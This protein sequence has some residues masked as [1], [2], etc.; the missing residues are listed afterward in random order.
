MNIFGRLGGKRLV[1]LIKLG[2]ADG[3]YSWFFCTVNVFVHAELQTFTFSGVSAEMS[4]QELE[5]MN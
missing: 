2:R 3:R 4:N 5:K 1:V